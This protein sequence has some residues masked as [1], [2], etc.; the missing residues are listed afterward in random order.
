[1]EV[2]A[3][4]FQPV[5]VG[6]SE[7]SWP[8][9]QNEEN[10][11]KHGP[12]TEAEGVSDSQAGVM[13]KLQERD[14]IGR[15]ELVQ[16]LARENCQF[17]QTDKRDQEKSEHQDDEVLT[18]VQVKEQDQSVLVLKKVQS[19]GPAPPTGSSETDWSSRLRVFDPHLERKESAALSDR[20]LPLPTFDVPYFKYIDEEDEDDEWSS[21][22]QSSTEDDSV[23]SLLSDRYVVV[24]GTPEKILEHLLNDLHLEEVQD[25]ETETLLDD[26]LLTYTVFM[27]TD[28]LCQALLRQY[29]SLPSERCISLLSD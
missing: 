27:T 1:M 8:L 25:K 15:I 28:D 7:T 12:V 6:E 13:C 20:E 19:C 2:M 17:L 21:R 24:S 29:P 23:D 16:K 18:T 26:F 22:S 5:G 3:H 11:D 10:S 4:G 14:D 9:E